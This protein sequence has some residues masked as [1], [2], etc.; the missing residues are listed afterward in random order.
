MKNHYNQNINLQ[1]TVSENNFY[2]EDAK[3][4][5]VYT[6]YNGAVNEN[7]GEGM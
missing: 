1:F 7:Y 6:P 3:V 2:K 4:E 5:V